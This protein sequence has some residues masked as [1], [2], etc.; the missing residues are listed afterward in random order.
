LDSWENDDRAWGRVV[1]RV[2]LVEDD[3]AIAEVVTLILHE[4]GYAVDRL[5]QAP[6]A[7]SVGAATDRFWSDYGR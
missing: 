6:N 2:L 4:S 1:K 3:E 7:S 5:A